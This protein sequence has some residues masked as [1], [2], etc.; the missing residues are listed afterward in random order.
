[1]EPAE[2]V[3][4][5]LKDKEAKARQLTLEMIGDLPYA[6]IKPPEHVLFVCKLNPVTRDEDLELIFSRFGKINNCEV[7][8]DK[9][10][11]DSLSYAFIEFDEKSACEEAYF[12]MQ[13]VL[14]DDRRIHVDFSQSV[15]KLH[16]SW[17]KDRTSGK[18]LG[19]FG[20]IEKRSKYR[21]EQEKEAD[22]KFVFESEEHGPE[23]AE[24]V[25]KSD[26]GRHQESKS[27]RLP[28]SESKRSHDSYRSHEQSSRDSRHESD[29]Y[30]NY[31]HDRR[32]Y[33]REEKRHDRYQDDRRRRSRE[34][35][36][37]R[38]PSDRRSYR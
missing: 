35:R 9:L 24:K 18:G 36:R 15:S 8:R 5:K 10:T 30:K 29:K 11:G 2:V 4:K 34:R 32:D 26:R 3:E 25:E 19:G 6:D 7:I 22:Y 28:H 12:K 23:I 21:N 27:D 31:S 38:S 13:N 33:R 17:I 20:D 14:I 1:M 16:K 37:S